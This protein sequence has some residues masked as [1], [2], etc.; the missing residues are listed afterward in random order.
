MELGGAPPTE[1]GWRQKAGE[2][3]LFVACLVVLALAVVAGL[4]LAADMLRKV[5]GGLAP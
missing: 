3:G 4:V 2:V 1:P 5:I